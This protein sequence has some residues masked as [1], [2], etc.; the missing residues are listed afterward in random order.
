MDLRI[1]QRFGQLGINYIKPQMELVTKQADMQITQIPAVIDI[2]IAY[3][4]VNIDMSEVR[5]DIGYKDILP[6][7]KEHANEGQ[8]TVLSRIERIAAEGNTLARS[9]GKG[10]EII[11]Q[12]AWN[13]WFDNYEISVDVVPH[14]PPRIWFTGGTYFDVKPGK[15]D[16][17]AQINF[18]EIEGVP[19]RAEIYLAQEPMIKVEAVGKYIDLVI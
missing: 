18:P 4:Q 6:F 13:N 11:G 15:V 16:I 8:A 14:T 12:I 17:D 7:A 9:A 5:A 10:R 19:G 1:T 2:S 3:P